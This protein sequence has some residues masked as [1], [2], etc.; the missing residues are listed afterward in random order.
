MLKQQKSVIMILIVMNSH[1]KNN[2]EIKTYDI[3]NRLK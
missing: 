1:I 3:I 2:T